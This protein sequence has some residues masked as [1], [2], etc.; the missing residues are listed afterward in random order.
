MVS[1][2]VSV[3]IDRS[4]PAG[5]RARYDIER[6]A[7][8]WDGAVPANV[9]VFLRFRLSFVSDGK[10]LRLQFSADQF[11]TLSMDGE[12]VARGPDASPPWLYAF[13]EHEVEASAGEHVLEALVWW[14]G[15]HAP[16]SRMTAGP[17][18]VLAGVG[19]R[20]ALL[21]TGVAPWRVARVHGWAPEPDAPQGEVLE[22]GDNGLI[23]LAL[24]HAG[25]PEWREP[26][27]VMAPLGPATYGSRWGVRNLEPSPLPAM[28][29]RRVSPG[30]IVALMDGV[31]GDGA[32][33]AEALAHPRLAEAGR[34]LSE[35]G[36]AF[37]VPAGSAATLVWDLRDYFSG[38]PELVVSGGRGA[39]IRQIWG[40]SFYETP[41]VREKRKGHR[42]VVAGKYL[43]EGLGDRFR[44]DGTARSTLAPYWWRCGRY[45]VVTV[46]TGAEDL[47][48]H[49]LALVESG[50]VFD[51][52][53][54]FSCD[55]DER[56]R[57][58]L[59]ICRRTLEVSSWD[60]YQDSPYYEQ[61][62][63]IGDTRLEM[64]MTYVVNGNDVL[65]RRGLELLES[66]RQV[67]EGLPAS[68]FPSRGRQLITSFC[69]KYVLMVHD[70]GWWRDDAA[71]VRR[72]LP[73]VRTTL[74]RF[75]EWVNAEGLL[76][77][78]HGWPYVDWVAGWP[79]GIP[80]AA[81][82]GICGLHNLIHVLA[83][84]AAAELEEA[85]GEPELAA[86]QKRRA[87]RAAAATRKLFWNEERGCLADDPQHLHWS[88]H[89]QIYGVLAGVL[90]AEEGA[91]AF[92]RARADKAFAV[93]SYVGRFY[94][95]EALRRIGR[96]GEILGE[97]DAWQGM[98]DLGAVTVW[99]QLEPTRSD[100]HAWSSHPL[101]HLPC[102]VLGV[103]PAAPGFASVEIAPQPGGLRRIAAKVTH[104]RGVVEAELEF[105]E[106]GCSGVVRLPEGVD[107][108]FRLGARE[109]ALRGGEQQVSLLLG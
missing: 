87:D 106:R 39:E 68:R 98:L 54:S 13:S 22:T 35:A 95:F 5:V 49:E 32:V 79:R 31:L 92:A 109:L 4:C 15:E 97:L 80:P 53:G 10:P 89:A 24:A 56:L 57:P 9:P 84:R 52:R 61:L 18:F 77:A 85:Y 21:S 3:P 70:F 63:Y 104:P 16:G 60:T 23:D 108:V 96:G 30:R 7:W 42:D 99:E 51:W 40:E 6:V 67:W 107:G 86:L 75:R 25:E 81:L 72:L 26:I 27:K 62:M 46:T 17:G 83:L 64:L 82:G 91:R 55:Q 8:L 78:V 19:D 102:S 88:W 103:R 2:R 69:L 37:V 1:R 14:M 41:R 36:G 44:P 73:G 20:H 48:L 12:V 93:P 100:C 65:P 47:T 59:R 11:A 76:E 45:C 66:S 90:T 50:H 29:E 43:P 58:I 101:F 94:L 105:D 34:V 33:P 38:W 28:P 74:D 71:L